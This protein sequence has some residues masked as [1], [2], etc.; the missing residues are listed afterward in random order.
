MESAVATWPR[1]LRQPLVLTLASS[2]FDVDTMGA[3]DLSMTSRKHRQYWL[4]HVVPFFSTEQLA[5][6]RY[7]KLLLRGV[8]V[9]RLPVVAVTWARQDFASFAGLSFPA[10][11]SLDLPV[12]RIDG[13]IAAALQTCPA[14]QS[15]SLG[16]ATKLSRAG[17][18]ALAEHSGSTLTRLQCFGDN[19]GFTLDDLLAFVG[20]CSRLTVLDVYDDDSGR[21]GARLW[22]TQEAYA[23]LMPV[24]HLIATLTFDVD[25]MEE[26]GFPELLTACP[27]LMT[28]T[29]N[30]S[31][32][33][34]SVDADVEGAT[35]ISPPTPP[36]LLNR[37]T[38]GCCSA[39]RVL[40]VVGGHVPASLIL[41]LG[42]ACPA[43][44][45]LHL[46]GCSP[47]G[48]AEARALGALRASL[49]KLDLEPACPLG[50]D[51]ILRAIWASALGL[52]EVRVNE[53]VPPHDGGAPTC[54]P[55][56][57]E[58]L[59]LGLRSLDVRYFS[60]VEDADLDERAMGTALARCTQLTHVCVR[61]AR[62]DRGVCL[63]S[64]GDAALEALLDA[65][66]AGEEPALSPAR[67]VDV[68]VDG[69]HAT[70]AGL[71]RLAQACPA[72]ECVRVVRPYEDCD[73]YPL[74]VDRDDIDA[75]TDEC[76]GRVRVTV[77]GKYL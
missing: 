58:G 65:R 31:S 12:G 20:R 22:A 7:E 61:W 54:T 68:T 67:L 6:R 48:E 26:A 76:D 72:L 64:L 24:G 45:Y 35:T 36:M 37:L 60:S 52:T 29:H 39:L 46:H 42:S 40:Y 77:V 53:V 8:S 57:F 34:N 44:G 32:D 38:S 55:A 50:G 4:D 15:V 66:G 23:R 43:L 62:D 74:F 63:R 69:A 16:P 70:V 33:S 75:F 47:F 2:F 73:N 3:L 28:F 19:D 5:G 25:V 13:H 30:S 49:R 11:L 14:L 56:A 21:A 10:L 1:V 17:L 59:P 51:A 9:R 27:N 71:A 41:G 18:V